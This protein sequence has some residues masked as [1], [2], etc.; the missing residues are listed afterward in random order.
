MNIQKLQSKL[1]KIKTELARSQAR[2]NQLNADNQ[3]NQDEKNNISFIMPAYNC[4]DT[5]EESVDSIFNGNFTD[6]DEL[7]IVNDGSTD[8]T[9]KVLDKSFKPSS[10]PGWGISEKYCC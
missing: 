2:L 4:A 8:N 5:I 3:K 6:G 7:I 10:K 9:E 1:E